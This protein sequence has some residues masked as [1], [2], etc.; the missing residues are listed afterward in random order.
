MSY[1]A[2]IQNPS[3]HNHPYISPASMVSLDDSPAE[4]TRDDLDVYIPSLDEQCP[5]PFRDLF[6]DPRISPPPLPSQESILRKLLLEDAPDTGCFR[7]LID[8]FADTY[9]HVKIEESTF[10]SFL[11]LPR[12]IRD[13]IWEMAIPQRTLNVSTVFHPGFPHGSLKDARLPI[14]HIGRVCRE[15][16][17]TVLRKGRKL[18]LWPY[19]YPGPLREIDLSEYKKYQPTGFLMPTDR[20]LYMDGVSEEENCALKG[21]ALPPDG[22]ETTTARELPRVLGV[23]EVAVYWHEVLGLRSQMPHDDESD[24]E[25]DHD[26]KKYWDFLRGMDNT[27]T[28]WVVH[29]PPYS[30]IRYG[31]DREQVA[32]RLKDHS[33]GGSCNEGTRK[34]SQCGMFDVLV[35]LYDDQKMAEIVSLHDPSEDQAPRNRLDSAF[36]CFNCKR[37]VWEKHLLPVAERFW[38]LLHA[39]ELKGSEVDEVF[40]TDEGNPLPHR[41]NHPWVQEKLSQGPQIR[42]AASFTLKPNI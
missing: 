12:E 24:E 16:L 5:H 32:A 4:N 34:P 37:L 6:R 22:V 17:E 23:S 1:P 27:M 40:P 33:P 7:G 42:P 28:L 15:A 38:L 11:R 2:Q 9:G 10:P 36:H 39:G 41:R 29:C 31:G 20:L 13:M 35:D 26:E 30:V 18:S 8:A 25:Y 19:S 14:P 3:I 21:A